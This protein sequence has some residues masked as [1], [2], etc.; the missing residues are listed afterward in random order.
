MGMSSIRAGRRFE[1]RENS[2]TDPGLNL[3]QFG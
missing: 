2:T 1:G 3:G